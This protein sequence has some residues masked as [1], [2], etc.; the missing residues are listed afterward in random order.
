MRQQRGSVMVTAL[1]LTAL[2]VAVLGSIA[3]SQHLAMGA[4]QSQL[5]Q[6]R[7]EAAARAALAHAIAELGEA[8]TNLVT[9]QDDWALL[10]GEK[11]T[12]IYTL[13]D[14][15]KYRVQI[16]DANSLINVNNA[17]QQQLEALP[18][19]T[20]EVASLL[21]WRE[22][23]TNARTDGA[24]DE[25]YNQLATPYNAKL[26][27]L[28]TL[29]ELLLVREWTAAMLYVP[30]QEAVS[31]AEL[32]EDTDGNVL[33]LASLLT[34][35]D[36]APNLRADGT[37][38]V[39]VN[40]APT[41]ALW[42]QL[43]ITGPAAI[44]LSNGGAAA[45]FAQ[46][47]IRPGVTQTVAQ[48]LLDGASFG[49]E[50]RYEGKI[51][52]NTA[53]EAVLKT[54]PNLTPDVAASLVQQQGTGLQSL[55]ELASVSGLT[56]NVLAQIADSLTVGSDTFIVRAWGESGGEGVAIEAT[57][58]ITDGKPSIIAL[59]QLPE[60]SVP[61]WWNWVPDEETTEATQQ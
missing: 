15:A 61:G 59:D 22:T 53:P 46:L 32:P 47:L 49:T 29:S 1:I 50:T 9:L 24:K 41:P 28:D 23:G 30:Q 44:Q 17:N 25:Y 57:I 38:R 52:V 13:A 11:G 18:L 31:A 4:Y 39:N 43:G 7:A 51:N 48:Q 6:R 27:R 45:T 20:E 8:D 12:E 5:R 37:A 40:V 35:D 54:I 26:K 19:T 58:R 55:G 3:A 10:G 34:V 42:T 16:V 56:T 21:D 60:V 36:G 33:P 14:D 2:L